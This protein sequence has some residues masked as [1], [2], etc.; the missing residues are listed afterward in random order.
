MA[1]E[2][3]KMDLHQHFYYSEWARKSCCVSANVQ[4]WLHV[5]YGRVNTEETVFICKFTHHVDFWHHV[6]A[7]H[8]YAHPDCN[9][10][11]W[12]RLHSI[13]MYIGLHLWMK[14]CEWRQ[15]WS[16]I[17]G[18]KYDTYLQ[19]PASVGYHI[20]SVVYPPSPSRK[21][22]CPVHWR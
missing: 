19:S 7:G 11:P 22:C 18:R 12:R 3:K 13:K 6:Y 1:W 9:R 14:D 15:K 2:G 10:G 16:E 4:R 5:L 8:V 17:D 21:T 20:P